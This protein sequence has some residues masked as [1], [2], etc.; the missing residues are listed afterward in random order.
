MNISVLIPA[1]NVE[2]YINRSINSAL[3]QTHCSFEI[4]VI[5]DGSTDDTKKIVKNYKNKVRY[6]SQSNQGSSSARN[7]GIRES[8]GDWIAFLDSDDE[9]IE[10]HLENFVK[11]QKLY[12]KIKWYGAPFI[13]LDEKSKQE[14]FTVKKG[15]LK[16]LDTHIMFDDY[17]TAFPP[18]AYLGSP[19]M[20]IHKSVFEKVGF[21][22]V[23]KKTAVDVDMWFRIGL[24]FSEIGYTFRIGTIVYRRD[25][26][27]STSK[28]WNPHKSIKRFIESE[29]LMKGNIGVNPKNVEARIIYWVTKLIRSC[30]INLDKRALKEIHK[31]Y[32]WRIPF[33]YK[34]IL[35]LA[36]RFHF[37][38]KFY[39]FFINKK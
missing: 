19:T 14:V 38:L 11:T 34:I 26:S 27:L 24:V 20:I 35:V 5:D 21:F 33:E 25:F 9:W 15:H 18:K 8:K 28:K 30:I 7:L 2:K 29:N 17:M 6:I 37:V 13:M 3:N 1:Y 10:T 32:F 22:D 31:I 36:I 16:E 12:P 4:I 39:N 23:S